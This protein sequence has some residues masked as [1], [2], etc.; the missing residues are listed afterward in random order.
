MTRADRILI[1]LALC[2]MP[3]VYF[4]LWFSDKPANYLLIQSG[5]NAP[6]TEALRPNRMLNISGPLGE[7]IVEISNG[8]ARFA[9]SPCTG[10]VCVHSGWLSN[11]GGF[12]AC[13]PNRISL[14]LTGQHPRFDAVN[15]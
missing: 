10:K 1:L 14:T 2:A 9:S 6:V 4:H 3:L 12:S 15:F 13:L 11:A 8:R 5:G 7:S